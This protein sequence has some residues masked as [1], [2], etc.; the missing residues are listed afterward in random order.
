MTYLVEASGLRKYFKPRTLSIGRQTPPV[1][2]VENFSIQL[3]RAQTIGLVG[4]SGCGKS[5][6]ARL[7]LRLI[8]PDSGQLF[9]DGEDITRLEADRMRPLRRNMQLVF[10]DPYASLNP[11]R[12]VRETIEEMLIVHGQASGERS[13]RVRTVLDQVGLRSDIADRYPHELSGGQRQRVAIA[14]ALVL[15]PSLIVAD[16]PVSALDVS[17]QAQVLNLLV[18]L[19]QS[20]QLAYLVVSHDLA[21]IEHLCDEVLV[22]YLGRVVERA[23]AAEIC[24]RPLHPYTEALIASVPKPVFSARST[25]RRLEGEVPSPLNPPS[26]CAF[27]TRCPHRLPQC[28]E[29][30]PALVNIGPNRLVACHLHAQS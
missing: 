18:D 20:E 21:V 27:H 10:Q 16:E 6:A 13:D 26:G 1:K 17:I 5:T 2:A 3:K 25:Q 23:S 30:V 22:M 9:F 7:L 19:Q 24:A 28:A 29:Q 12:S 4:E 8:E 14:R 15:K 11:R